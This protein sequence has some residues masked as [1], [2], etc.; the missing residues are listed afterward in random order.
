[1][2]HSKIFALILAVLM[3]L[4]M[5]SGC[6][7]E[8]AESSGQE[9]GEVSEQPS[10]TAETS[11]TVTDMTGKEITLE[12][13]ATRV[14]ALTASDCEILYAIGAG[15]T[16]VGRGEYC[17]YPAEVADVPALQ[18]GD[19]TNIE[20]II[21]LAPQV[22]IMS[23][24]AQTEEQIAQLETAG[25]RVVVSDAQDIEGVYAAIELIGAL[26]GKDNEA[27]A[28][29]LDMRDTFDA[30]AAEAAEKNAGDAGKTVYFEVSPLQYGLWTAGTGTF[31]N[32]VA[33]ML[34]LANCF[35]DVSGWGEISEEQVIERN[36]DY[37]VTIAMYFGEGPTP[38]EEI[39]S[40]AG[41]ENITAIKNGEI[42][43]LQNN[44][45]SRP[46]PRLADGAQALFDFVYQAAD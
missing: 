7:A 31:M 1:M 33:E 19:N 44:E 32:E 43:N 9:N 14:V 24:M 13:P 29:V 5:T 40:R 12:G 41:W 3:I 45:L 18:S 6:K 10:E 27:A 4:T 11:L 20:Q 8:P 25:I 37:I 36:P 15:D 38:D 34:G 16:L 22:L 17:D 42:L 23:T 21:A 28:L 46:G 26:T 35:A 2:K 39:V 30:L